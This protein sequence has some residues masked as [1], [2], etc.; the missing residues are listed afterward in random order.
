MIAAQV[1]RDH[2]AFGADDFMAVED[3]ADIENPQPAYALG[4]TA[5]AGQRLGVAQHLAPHRVGQKEAVVEG[6]R[7]SICTVMLGANVAG[8]SQSGFLRVSGPA[9]ITLRSWTMRS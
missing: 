7:T 8:C 4:N 9:Q 3:E 1:C 2:R 5:L 6:G